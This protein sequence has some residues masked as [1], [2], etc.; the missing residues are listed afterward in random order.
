MKGF[1]KP[2]FTSMILTL[3]CM[4]AVIGFYI[5]NKNIVATG[6]TQAGGAILAGSSGDQLTPLADG[7]EAFAV[8][9]TF[10]EPLS[11]WREEY[12]YIIPAPLR[13]LEQWIYMLGH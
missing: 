4:G 6:Y 11:A 9:L 8:D 13:A 1:A 3:L 5:S 10:L 2:F 7:E 12:Y